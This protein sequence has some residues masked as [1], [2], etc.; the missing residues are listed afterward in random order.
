VKAD[1]D[2][3]L[4]MNFIDHRSYVTLDGRQVLYGEDWAARKK[5]LWERSGGRC[6]A[7]LEI[8][9][10]VTPWRCTR[11]ATEPHHVIRR[12]IQRDDRMQNLQA[13]CHEHHAMLDERKPRWT[14]HETV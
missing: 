4:A 7:Q 3:T 5:A 11:E 6:E 10:G 12:H 9:G 1:R 8:L 14:K 13:L 2:L